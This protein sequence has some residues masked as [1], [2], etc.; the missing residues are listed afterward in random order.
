M[1]KILALLFLLS[2]MYYSQAQNLSDSPGCMD[3]NATNY[4]PR[5]TSQALDREGNLLCIY[6]SCDD[7]PQE[8]CI[9]RD[10]FGPY[11][12]GFGASECI[13]NGGTSCVEAPAE[14][15]GCTYSSAV[16]YN[17]EATRDN[18]SCEWSGESETHMMQMPEG[19][20]M[21]G[22]ICRESIS[23]EEAFAG[24]EDKIVVVK[25]GDGNPYLPQFGYNG[26]GNLEYA[27]GYQLKLTEE[28]RGLTFCGKEK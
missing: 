16:N 15:Y 9:Y 4:D 24:L 3:E 14:I 12:E 5:A 1:K 2:G 22:Y 11:A 28:I 8:G 17:S 18:G 23:V 27:R 13:S 10:S 7:V 19:W 25:D 20:S 26:L 6:S 21:F